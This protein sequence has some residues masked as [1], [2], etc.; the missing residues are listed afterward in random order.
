MDKLYEALGTVI[1]TIII[2]LVSSPVIKKFKES[3]QK[4]KFKR[5][6]VADD[7]IN[8]IL[9]DLRSTY[10]FN[11]ASLIEYHNGTTSLGGFGFKNASMRNES[12]DEITKSIILDFQNIPCGIIASM[13]VELEKSPK[14]YVN[15]GDDSSDESVNVTHRMYGVKQAWDFRIGDS[16]VDG[17]VSLIS[18]SKNIILSDDDILDIK[19][20]CQRILLYKRGFLH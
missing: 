11:R 5:N 10:G 19:S 14:G 16:L 18:T 6:L 7:K 4:N 1:G 2:I 8:S 17:C 3:K 15:V 13:L 9:S 20:K 12:T